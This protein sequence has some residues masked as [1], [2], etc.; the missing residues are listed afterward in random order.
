MP[1]KGMRSMRSHGEERYGLICHSK[2]TNPATTAETTTKCMLPLPTVECC[3]VP[4]AGNQRSVYRYPE[5]GFQ[6]TYFKF[7]C[8]RGDRLRV[9]RNHC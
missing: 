6:T 3:N 4:D 1:S 9:P 7:W 2:Y 5:M 8:R